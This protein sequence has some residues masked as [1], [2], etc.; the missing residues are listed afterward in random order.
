MMEW[1][2][3]PISLPMP[4]TLTL[5]SVGTSLSE[6]KHSSSALLGW[7]GV[8]QQRSSWSSHA[9]HKIPYVCPPYLNVRTQYTIDSHV[10]PRGE[11][12]QP[13]TGGAVPNALN[14]AVSSPETQRRDAWQAKAYVVSTAAPGPRSNEK[15]KEE[16]WKHFET[17]YNSGENS[18]RFSLPK[19]QPS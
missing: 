12:Q 18:T 7:T 14:P 11:C 1:I 3:R 6:R 19:V 16:T 5:F 8:K 2:S 15:K 4:S 17:R 10:L 13:R 9:N